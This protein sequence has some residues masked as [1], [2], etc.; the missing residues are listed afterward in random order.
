MLTIENVAAICHAANRELCLSQ[1]DASHSEWC[2][3]AN[4]VR[5]STIK[6]VMFHVKNPDATPKDSHEIWLAHKRADGWRY[7]VM[8]N[9]ATREHPYM[10]PY[11]KL[12]DEQR[13]KDQLFI[14]I[15]TAAA[16][17]LT[18]ADEES[19]SET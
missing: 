10:V 19:P 2:N 14:A 1:G 16:P 9:P 4:W 15:V 17:F 5:E 12:T 6:L 8:K 7:G 18:L 3:A 11:D 13:L